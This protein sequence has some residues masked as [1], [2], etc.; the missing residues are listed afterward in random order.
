MRYEVLEAGAKGSFVSFELVT[1][2]QHQV[3]V[4]SMIMGHPLLGEKMYLGGHGGKVRGAFR[5][6]ALHAATLSFPHPVSGRPLSFESPLPGDLKHL[7]RL[8][9]AGRSA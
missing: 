1:G 3:R 6:Q 2:R 8:Q 5:R 7:L 4:L 9:R